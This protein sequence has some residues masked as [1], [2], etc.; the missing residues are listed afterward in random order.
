MQRFVYLI[1]F[2]IIALIVKAFF[3]DSYL[4][5]KR[6]SESNASVETAQPE[7]VQSE[8]VENNISGMAAEKKKN[9]APKQE[10]MPLDKLGDSI[11]EKIEDKL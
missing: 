10:G 8:P 4:K 11:A 6:A 1:I 2:L 7:E 3:V 5:E 9:S